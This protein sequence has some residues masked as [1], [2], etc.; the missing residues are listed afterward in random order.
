LLKAALK[1]FYEIRVIRDL[2]KKPSTSELL[3]WLNALI[4]GGVSAERLQ[5]EL[6]FLGV[7]IKKDEDLEAVRKNN[8]H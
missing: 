1:R 3:D 6:P 7:I 5:T 8:V 2:R 4:I